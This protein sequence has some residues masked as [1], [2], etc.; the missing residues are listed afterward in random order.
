MTEKK[1]ITNLERLVDAIANANQSFLTLVKRQ[2][3]TS[4]TL[5]N[6]VI[7]YYIFEYEQAGQDRAQYGEQVLKKLAEKLRRVGLKGMSFS[8]LYA[9]KQFYLVYPQLSEFALEYL[10]SDDYQRI[11]IFQSLTGKS[12][13]PVT[14]ADLLLSK[15]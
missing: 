15:L 2:V 11:G 9:C 5:R 3:N 8:N 7:G 6:W 12:E 10:Q 1:S 14:E 4:L 13:L